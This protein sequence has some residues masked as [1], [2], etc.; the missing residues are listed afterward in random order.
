M[1]L[2]I[3]VPRRRCFYAKNPY[4]RKIFVSKIGCV[5]RSVLKGIKGTKGY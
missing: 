1:L 4:L 3:I 5:A 2:I